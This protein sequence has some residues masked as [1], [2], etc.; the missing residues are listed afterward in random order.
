MRDHYLKIIL[1]KI[2]TFGLTAEQKHKL[3]SAAGVRSQQ[4]N[5]MK[6]VQK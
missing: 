2:D 5:G 6:F 3:T 4:A 1:L